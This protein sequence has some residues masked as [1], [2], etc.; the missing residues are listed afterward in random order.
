M[1]NK[2]KDKYTDRQHHD[3]EDA[4]KSEKREGSIEDIRNSQV[5]M[6]NQDEYRKPSGEDREKHAKNS[7]QHIEQDEEYSRNDEERNNKG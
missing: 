4:E 3:K 2:D 7:G 5:D 6:Q 1:D